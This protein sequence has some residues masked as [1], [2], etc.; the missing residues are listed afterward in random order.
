MRPK[1]KKYEF[2][3]PG[4]F[5]RLI[6]DLTVVGSL[7]GG[8]V[9]KHVK[10]LQETFSYSANFHTEF[11]STP[12]YSSLHRVFDRLVNSNDTYLPYFSD[13]ACF[14]ATCSDGRLLLNLDFVKCDTSHTKYLFDFQTDCFDRN[15]W[16]HQLI[17]RTLKQLSLPF[18]LKSA[19]GIT[20]TKFRTEIPTLFSGSTATTGTNNFAY[21]FSATLLSRINFRSIT[22]A[23]AKRRIIDSFKRAGYILELVDCSSNPYLLQ[24]LK[25]SPN[26]HMQPYLNIATILRTFGQCRG[27]LPGRRNIPLSTRAHNFHFSLCQTFRHAGDSCVTRLLTEKYQTG[28][29]VHI[30]PESAFVSISH[31]S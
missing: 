13:D 10:K 5:P 17:C 8:F 18:V 4:K 15:T 11:I 20:K 14:G 16:A 21:L 26:E 30:R 3:K 12:S 31:E 19:D 9:Y 29:L 6:A 27:D 25:H 24:F 28:D 2:A 23:D 22:M 1:L 7:L